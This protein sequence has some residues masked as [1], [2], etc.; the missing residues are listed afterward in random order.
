MVSEQWNNIHV[1]KQ[2]YWCCLKRK[3]EKY[4]HAVNVDMNK[5]SSNVN[6]A[7]ITFKAGWRPKSICCLNSGFVQIF[8]NFANFE[9]LK[10]KIAS[11]K[12]VNFVMLYLLLNLFGRGWI[13][14]PNN[15]NKNIVLV[16]EAR[17]SC[18]FYDYQ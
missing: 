12:C 15:L 6:I 8:P 10:S 7:N 9:I 3:L 1:F 17:N 5:Y 16:R 18:I 14:N 2:L 4:R 13:I 11:E